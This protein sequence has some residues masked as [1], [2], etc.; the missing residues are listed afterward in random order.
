M[1]KKQLIA[2]KLLLNQ[3][4]QHTVNYLEKEATRVRFFVSVNK[5]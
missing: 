2:F 4:T 1:G 3:V 5:G